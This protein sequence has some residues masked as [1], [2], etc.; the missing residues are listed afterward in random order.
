MY[1]MVVV[2]LDGTLLNDAKKVSKENADLI[3][4]AYDEKGIITVIATGR[5]LG[6]AK[7]ICEQYG[8]YFANYIIAANGAIVKNIKTNEYIT[9]IAF[10]DE[11]V[12]TLRNIYLEEKIDYLMVYTD[13]K[14]ITETRDNKDFEDAGV[15]ASQ[16]KTKVENIEEAI[17]NNSNIVKLCLMGG[18]I[19]A[20]EK[21]IEKISK[22]DGIETSVI[23]SYLYKT[24]ESTFESKYIDINKS[25]CSKKNAI[26][27][28]ADKLGI[29][30]EEIIVMGDGRKRY[31][32]V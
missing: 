28:L 31:I 25:G 24:E 4:R 6:Y 2:D 11:E 23:C 14:V 10:T 8:D 9:N 13:E 17:K 18:E 12:L 22:L 30:K 19:S 5:P 7:E 29:K 26:H 1:K 21:I 32:N 20:L 16:K 27:T 3:K 15:S